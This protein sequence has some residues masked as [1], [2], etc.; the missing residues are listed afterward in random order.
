VNPKARYALM[1]VFELIVLVAAALAGWRWFV[2]ALFIVEASLSL[3]LMFKLRSTRERARVSEMASLRLEQRI[4]EIS[5]EERR[6]IGHDLHDGL[7]QHLTAIALMSESLMQRMSSEKSP[8]PERL[9]SFAEQA[10]KITSMVSQSIGWTRDLARGLSPLTLESEGLVAA[11]EE[12]AINSSKLL[13]IKCVFD[14]DEN[15][16]EL[17]GQTGSHVYRIVQEAISN[18]V[19]HGK[20]H[21]ITVDLDTSGERIKVSILDDG[22]GL[23]AKTMANPGIGLR[24]MQYRAKMISADLEINRVSNEGGTRVTCSFPRR[25]DGRTS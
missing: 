5:E 24:I 15:R 12:L 6:R 9:E 17:D 4:L 11:L 19:R 21:N 10:E 22:S 25:S 14:C 1:L 23:S 2:C 20:A 7:G 16:L 18:S 8:S 13:S 3:F